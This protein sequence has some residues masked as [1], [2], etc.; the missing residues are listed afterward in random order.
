MLAPAS[1]VVRTTLGF[2]VNAP[3]EML[4]CSISKDVEPRFEI[5]TFRDTGVPTLTSPKSID[6]GF[7]DSFGATWLDV[8]KAPEFAPQPASA[9][10]QAMAA[11]ASAMDQPDSR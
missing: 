9:T 10:A 11:I 3:P 1:R 2:T 6:E 8:E 4:N 5:D 7:M